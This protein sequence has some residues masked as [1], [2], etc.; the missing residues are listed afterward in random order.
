MRK[1][2]LIAKYT[3]AKLDSFNSVRR[4]DLALALTNFGLVAVVAQH[5][6]EKLHDIARHVH[7][8]LQNLCQINL[9]VSHKRRIDPNQDRK[10][11]SQNR[12]RLEVK[13]RRVLASQAAVAIGWDIAEDIPGSVAIDPVRTLRILD[14]GQQTVGCL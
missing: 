5:F 12:K 3:L 14:I 11:G 6:F 2:S 9:F 13:P 8:P 4:V 7:H 10:L 1:L